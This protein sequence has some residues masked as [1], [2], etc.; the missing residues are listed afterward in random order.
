MSQENKSSE[1]TFSFISSAWLYGLIVICF[2][3]K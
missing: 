2:L 3:P 1:I